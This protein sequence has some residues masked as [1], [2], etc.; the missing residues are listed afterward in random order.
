MLPRDSQVNYTGSHIRRIIGD[1]PSPGWI[2]NEDTLF[3]KNNVNDVSS[4]RAA[5]DKENAI[6]GLGDGISIDH[7]RF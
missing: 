5:F 7:W 3:G 4:L 1:V 6:R 2:A